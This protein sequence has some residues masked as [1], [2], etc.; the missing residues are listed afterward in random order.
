MAIAADQ[1]MGMV[2]DYIIAMQ[3]CGITARLKA[4]VSNTADHVLS[5]RPMFYEMLKSTA[6]LVTALLRGAAFLHRQSSI[7][8]H[9]RLA[10]L[11]ARIFVWKAEQ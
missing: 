10:G 7:D 5:L 1:A 11:L 2:A 6:K 3:L 9:L 8:E 4:L